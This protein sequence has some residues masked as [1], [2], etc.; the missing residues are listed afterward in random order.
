MSGYST[1]GWSDA[2]VNRYLVTY[3][4]GEQLIVDC[5]YWVRDKNGVVWFWC[6]GEWLHSFLVRDVKLLQRYCRRVP[7][8]MESYGNS[9]YTTS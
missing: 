1:V 3:T 9:N 5:G 4:N 2:D 6:D 8:E 7:K